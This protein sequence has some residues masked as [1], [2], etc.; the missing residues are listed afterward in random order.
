MLHSDFTKSK[1]GLFSIMSIVFLIG[2]E[3]P[4]GDPGPIGLTGPLPTQAREGFIK[5]SL[6]TKI[7]KDFKDFNFDFQGKNYGDENY[8]EVINDTVTNISVGKIYAVNGDTYVNG[9][10]LLAFTVKGMK[11]LDSL[12]AV[13]LQLNFKREISGQF[14]DGIVYSMPTTRF[15]QSQDSIRFTEV[16]YDTTTKII[17][18]KFYAKIFQRDASGNPLYENTISNGSFYSVIYRQ[19]RNNK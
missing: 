16:K 14:Y 19:Y 13:S 3:G 9:K 4:K 8:Y 17:Q 2:C 6:K 5:G 10:C 7:D 18:G 12:K 11:N 15:F 1:I